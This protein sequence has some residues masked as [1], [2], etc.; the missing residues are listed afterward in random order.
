[1]AQ[2]SAITGGEDVNA[3][4][5]TLANAIRTL[6]TSDDNLDFG[7]GA[8]FMTTQCT[9]QV[10]AGLKSGALEGWYVSVVL[11]SEYSVLI[12]SQAILYHI[13]YWNYSHR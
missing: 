4:P 3:L 12:L 13:L 8:W 7:S 9:E 1:M 11:P 10:R 2:V 5:A 6:L